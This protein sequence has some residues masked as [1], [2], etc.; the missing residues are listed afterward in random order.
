VIEIGVASGASTALLLVALADAG[1]R[2]GIVLLTNSE[3]GDRL[4]WPIVHDFTGR[5]EAALL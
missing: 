4:R 5:G 3:E 1:G 2:M